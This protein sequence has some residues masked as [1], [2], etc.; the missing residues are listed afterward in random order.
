[1]SEQPTVEGGRGPLVIAALS[2]IWFAAT[3]WVAHDAVISA[4]TPALAIV[5]AALVMPLVIAS[6]LLAGAAA[7]LTAI[8]RIRWR[9]A[10]V[11][12]G[13]GFVVGAAAGGL[14]LVG[15]GTATALVSLALA[16]TLSAAAGGAFAGIRAPAVLAGGL[17]GALVWFG[18]GLAEG[19]FTGSLQRLFA[20][21]RS[22]AA[23]VA[24][25]SRLSLTVAV[26]GGVAAGLCAYAYLR[27]RDRGLK[28]PAYLAAGAT[29][30][31]LLLAADV[32]TRLGG[33]P[34]LRLAGTTGDADRIA[35]NYVAANRLSTALVV[36]F[37]G[38][39]AAI[40]AFGRSLNRGAAP[41]PTGRTT[42]TRGPRR[43]PR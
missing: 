15:Y 41:A 2:L 9:P 40:L 19:L 13:A 24:A 33:R 39:I 32:A 29:P 43:R 35:I 25:A 11:G 23:Q 17:V 42:P 7:G 3:L 16:I 8:T 37:A 14:V 4:L 34:L 26:V 36:L 20:S 12:A 38:A 30:G 18:V 10:W 31:L 6:G 5:N 28:W 21:D 27:R 22:P 1:M